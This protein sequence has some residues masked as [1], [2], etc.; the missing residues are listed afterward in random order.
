MVI[1]AVVKLQD[2]GAVRPNALSRRTHGQGEVL[3]YRAVA[4]S[5]S[6]MHGLLKC[7]DVTG[8]HRVNARSVESYVAD[9][10]KLPASLRRLP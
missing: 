2:I 4:S 5:W 9:I 8:A 6:A 1:T 7:F 3:R 10:G